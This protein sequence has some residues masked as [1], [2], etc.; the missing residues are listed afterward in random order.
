MQRDLDPCG[1]AAGALQ[2][3]LPATVAHHR[4]ARSL[5]SLLR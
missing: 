5:A 2:G 4:S 3:E 1:V